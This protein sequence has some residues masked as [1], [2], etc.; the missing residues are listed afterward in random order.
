MFDTLLLRMYFC[1]FNPL[2]A[3]FRV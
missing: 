3:T 1:P 2:I